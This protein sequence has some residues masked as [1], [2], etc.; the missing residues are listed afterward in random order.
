MAAQEDLDRLVDAMIAN[1][2][3]HLDVEGDG[4]AFRLTL[5]ATPPAA[6]PAAQPSAPK[7]PAQSMTIGTFRPRGDD[8]GLAPLTKGAQIKLGDVLGYVAQEAVR[9]PV[10]APVTGRLVSTPPDQGT[11]LGYGDV[12]FELEV[13]P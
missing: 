2:V 1:G 13:E 12:I 6:T 9:L 8:D 5:G 10:I 4:M 11:L 7:I 3:T